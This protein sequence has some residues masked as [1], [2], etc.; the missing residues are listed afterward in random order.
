MARTA[1]TTRPYG[2]LA[3]TRAPR[4]AVIWAIIRI[5]RRGTLERIQEADDRLAIREPAAENPRAIALRRPDFSGV[6]WAGA[7]LDRQ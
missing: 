3:R 6:T 7:G 4:G 5:Q 2:R 1:R